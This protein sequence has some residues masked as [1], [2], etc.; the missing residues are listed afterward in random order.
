MRRGIRTFGNGGGFSFTGF[1]YN[2]RLRSYRAFVTDLRRTVVLRYAA[3]TV[4]SVSRRAGRLCPRPG[5]AR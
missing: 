2:Q 1:Y 4:V 3:R 5:R